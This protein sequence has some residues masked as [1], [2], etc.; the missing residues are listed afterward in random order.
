M[1]GD[2]LI[3]ERIYSILKTKIESG[4]MPVG[5]KIPSRADLCQ[6]F[7]ASE[8][9][10]RKALEMLAQDGF[11]ESC[12]RK[13]P[14]VIRTQVLP[15]IDSCRSFKPADRIVSHDVIQSGILLCQPLIRWGM[16]LCRGDEW[17]TPESIVAQM[18][19]GRDME[20]WR[21]S[22]RLWRFFVARIGN[23]LILRAV[24]SLGLNLDPLPGTQEFR[25][26]YLANLKKF[27][28]TVKKGG[29]PERVRFADMSVVYRF[30]T[31]R[32][33]G[34]PYYQVFDSTVRA[35]GGSWEQDFRKDEERYSRVYLDL[36]GQICIGNYNPGDRL[37]SH[38]QLQ[39]MYHVSVD[40]TVKA[41]EILQSWGV[42]TTKR[43]CGIFVTMDL[44]DLKGSHFPPQAL[45]GPIRRF[46][47][48]LE[49]LSL[50]I[51]NV[52]CHVGER[53]HKADIQ[54]LRQRIGNLSSESPHH[55]QL[56]PIVLL[57]FMVDNIQYEAL[58]DIYKVIQKNYSIGRSIPRLVKRDKTEKNWN[59]Y[60]QCKM[61]VEL[62]D[63][64]AVQAFANQISCMYLSVNKMIIRE[65]DRLDYS[66]AATE[67]YDGASLW[68]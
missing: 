10:V 62:L 11:L 18:D 61:A 63:E 32:P 43:G 36:L 12:Q 13:R 14:T 47:D 48:S 2:A 27:L 41:I 39:E 25:A 33:K 4:L 67:V 50:T 54:T 30:L 23:E 9:P 49:L 53:A 57:D 60:Q 56:A 44:N 52:A 17:N 31:G 1:K 51:A 59:V 6:E 34:S 46:L 58:R 3:Y 8:K 29:A 64:G 15:N 26:S 19:P 65:C 45:A 38:K 20:F 28:D 5:S 16:Y 40:T 24:D 42:V 21:L 66:K 55:Y 68:K 22:N 7:G 35:G 37:P